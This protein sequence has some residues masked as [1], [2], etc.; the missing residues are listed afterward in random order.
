MSL[1]TEGP[2]KTSRSFDEAQDDASGSST[3]DTWSDSDQS[4]DSKTALARHRDR[5][6]EQTRQGEDR[7]Q[8]LHFAAFDSCSATIWLLLGGW[9]VGWGKKCPVGGYSGYW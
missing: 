8:L 9:S 4:G 1:E 5:L 2:V 7:A 3:S 6:A